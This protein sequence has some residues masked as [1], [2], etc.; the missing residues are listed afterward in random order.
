MD[1]KK[2]VNNTKNIIITTKL[3][4]K[5]KLYP[6][7]LYILI[8]TNVKTIVSKIKNIALDIYLVFSS[9]N[10]N[11]FNAFLTILNLHNMIHNIH[12]VIFD[13]SL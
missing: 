5:F 10:S 12:I 11:L 1:I 2:I 4:K 9:F 7:F 6:K 8:P 3:S 13:N